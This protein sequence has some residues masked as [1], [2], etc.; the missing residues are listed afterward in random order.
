MLED[1]AS[2]SLSNEECLLLF[3]QCKALAYAHHIILRPCPAKFIQCYLDQSFTSVCARYQ[4]FE[5]T[6]YFKALIMLGIGMCLP[7][8]YGKFVM[9][10]PCDGV[11][12]LVG[13]STLMEN[14][15]VAS[16]A[17]SCAAEDFILSTRSLLLMPISLVISFLNW[18]I[19]L[20][21]AGR[22]TSGKLQAFG[23]KLYAAQVN[24]VRPYLVSLTVQ[25]S[26]G[27]GSFEFPMMS[28]YAFVIQF[29]I[30]GAM[31][32]SGVAVLVAFA[33]GRLFLIMCNAMFAIDDVFRS[34]VFGELTAVPIL[35][36]IMEG[37]KVTQS[38]FASSADLQVLWDSSKYDGSSKLH[39]VVERDAYPMGLSAFV[40]LDEEKWTQP[41]HHLPLFL[42]KV[43]IPDKNAVV[44]MTDRCIEQFGKKVWSLSTGMV[45]EDIKKFP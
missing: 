31:T 4:T 14:K 25:P 3:K 18:V 30:V 42:I 22:C 41:F 7:L 5:R 19:N 15:L 29:V 12:T 33:V 8:G 13:N 32:R 40:K 1:G 27:A 37:D 44:N 2:A 45:G 10:Y 28:Y 20:S 16:P 11:E 6:Y 35:S 34:M 24:F 38:V 39:E 17:D 36:R 9:E 43:Y 23:A 21:I 26:R